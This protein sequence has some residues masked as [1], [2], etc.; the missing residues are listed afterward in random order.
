MDVLQEMKIFQRQKIKGL[1]LKV[2][3]Q[4]LMC[5]S[6]LPTDAENLK[7]LGQEFND[8]YSWKVMNKTDELEKQRKIQ[9]A[10]RAEK[11]MLEKH[12]QNIQQAQTGQLNLRA[13]K[14]DPL[15]LEFDN[16]SC[17]IDVYQREI[18]NYMIL[19]AK[20]MIERE[21]RSLASAFE[22]NGKRLEVLIDV[23][24]QFAATLDDKDK[25]N[26]LDIVNKVGAVQ[27]FLT[28]IKNRMLTIKTLT[29]GEGII[30]R[31]K[32]LLTI[33]DEFTRGVIKQGEIEMRTRCDNL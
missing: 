19:T 3:L 5:R 22:M 25:L 32:D 29:G 26:H 18:Q 28:Q 17:E 1:R 20:R 9:L 30:I 31:T 7:L 24:Q 4:I 15:L 23:H 21:S 13:Q 6:L 16:S 14:I 12:V 2:C 11:A 8:L 33:L 27:K 10:Q